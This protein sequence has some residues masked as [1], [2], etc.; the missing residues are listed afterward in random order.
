MSVYS[1][2]DGGKEINRLQSGAFQR[3]CMAAGLH[4]TL[5]PGWI[6]ET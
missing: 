5:G 2:T 6:G 3:R 1:K 4:L